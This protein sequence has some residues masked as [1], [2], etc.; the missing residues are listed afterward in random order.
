MA[1]KA[2]KETPQSAESEESD[3]RRFAFLAVM[4]LPRFRRRD[5]SCESAGAGC[6]CPW[7]QKS[8]SRAQAQREEHWVRRRPL[9]SAR[10]GRCE[11]QSAA[12]QTFAAFDSRGN[13]SVER[14]RFPE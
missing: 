10:S 11:L 8:R 12:T 3:K 9:D 14:G 5:R 2:S 1:A 13:W 4:I 7:P 6:A